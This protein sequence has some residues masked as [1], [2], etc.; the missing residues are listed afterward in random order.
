ME[1][2]RKG[3]NQTAPNDEYLEARR[4]HVL[5]ER[6]NVSKVLS[7]LNEKVS[8]GKGNNQAAANDAYVESQ[9]MQFKL[10]LQEN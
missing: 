5:F 4:K 7:S 10:L 6:L 3:K 2:F 8:L 9:G 1:L